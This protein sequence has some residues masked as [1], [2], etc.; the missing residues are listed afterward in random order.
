M[1]TWLVESSNSGKDPEGGMFDVLSVTGVHQV[2][3][4]KWQPT[5]HLPGRS[6]NWQVSDSLLL[7]TEQRKMLLYF[8]GLSVD[9]TI[10]NINIKT[11][12]LRQI[13]KNY[14]V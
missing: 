7:S 11:T 6:Y 9:W 8:V 3:C 2:A 1:S 12:K 13:P 5:V 14:V 10:I 4:F